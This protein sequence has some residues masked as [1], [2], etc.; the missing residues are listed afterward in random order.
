MPDYD[1]PLFIDPED[2]AESPDF[3]WPTLENV[4]TESQI[5]EFL[6]GRH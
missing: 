4:L 1:I 6:N 2:G 5:E 3:E